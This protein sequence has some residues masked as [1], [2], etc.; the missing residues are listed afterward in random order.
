FTDQVSIKKIARA[1][2]RRFGVNEDCR[3]AN[4]IIFPVLL[5]G[6][7]CYSVKA[8]ARLQDWFTIAKVLAL[9]TVIL[10]SGY[11]LIFGKSMYWD[12]FDHI[13]E[14]NFRTFGSAAVAF[15][16][17]LFAYQGWAY[18]NTITEELINP[19]RNLPLAFLIS[20]TIVTVVYVLYNIALYV[21]LSPDEI[22]LHPAASVTYA[23]KIYGKFSFIMSLFVAISTFG[24]ANGSLM[25]SSRLF[26]CGAREGQMP[27]ILAMTNKHFRTPIPSVILMSMLAIGYILL[28]SNVFVLIN[29]SQTTVWVAYTLAGVALLVLR[30]KMPDAYRPIK[31]NIAIPII[32][33]IGG[34]T[35]VTLSAIGE[36][37]DTDNFTAFCQKLFML[38]DE[39]K[40][41]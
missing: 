29:A 23:N 37:K 20:M 26:F 24:S 15:Y 1:V 7:N 5:C 36:P 10:T 38:V 13:F 22:I 40:E 33:I 39:N 32:F 12:S 9:L 11:L 6:I 16:S 27:V 25:M 18:L 41:I 31:V 35:L 21:V 28:S 34:V 4:I 2:A 14:G 3:A 17:G 8:V 30:Y 19:R